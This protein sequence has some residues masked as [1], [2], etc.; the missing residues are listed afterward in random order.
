MHYKVSQK[1]DPYQIIHGQ[2]QI[3]YAVLKARFR[4]TSS[5]RG[6]HRL[7]TE[8]KEKHIKLTGHVIHSGIYNVLFRISLLS[9]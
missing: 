4:N 7:S 3:E 8:S 1:Q 2:S 5:P 9:R 6:D